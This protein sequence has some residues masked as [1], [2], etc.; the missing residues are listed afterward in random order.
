MK[1]PPLWIRRVVFAPA[2]LLIAAVVLVTLP[3][4]VPVVLSTH[5]FG[6]FR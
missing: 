2:V 4:I 3:V 1:L 6:R 5:Q